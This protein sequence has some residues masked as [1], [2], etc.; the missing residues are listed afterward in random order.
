MSLTETLAA[1]WN[2]VNRRSA[3]LRYTFVALVLSLFAALCMSWLLPSANANNLAFW[4]I[5]CLVALPTLAILGFLIA[6]WLGLIFFLTFGVVSL[7]ILI[8]RTDRPLWLFTVLV[9]LPTIAVLG[10]LVVRWI[11]VIRSLRESS[12]YLPDSVL[13]YILL[14]LVFSGP[15]CALSAHGD[16]LASA[17]ALQYDYI[18]SH[19][20]GSCFELHDLERRE[21]SLRAFSGIKRT[22]L[23]E[24]RW[25]I[26]VSSRSI[27]FGL[28]SASLLNRV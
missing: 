4:L 17:E 12:Q 24:R 8:D 18:F 22:F 19:S 10:Y 26:R 20:S 3:E 7:L 23:V 2:L 27:A 1:F 14:A 15:Y 9:A 25:F 16:Y 11:R 28:P 13:H 6:R 5:A 21:S